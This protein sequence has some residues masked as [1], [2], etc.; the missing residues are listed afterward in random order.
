[1]LA[2]YV[3]KLPRHGG[4]ELGDT[5][6]PY[7]NPFCVGAWMADHMVAF[8]PR[9][10]GRNPAQHLGLL[11]PHHIRAAI[12]TDAAQAGHDG[13]RRRLALDAEQAGGKITQVRRRVAVGD[14]HPAESGA[15]HSARQGGQ[16]LGVQRR[17]DL[18]PETARGLPR[19]EFGHPE[20][21]VAPF[22]RGPIVRHHPGAEI[23]R[24]PVQ[25]E[26]AG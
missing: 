17:P 6:V 1:M 14:L 15:D 13:D 10:V 21:E 18:L 26:E 24:S 16:R 25:G 4:D 19:R 3:E 12:R 2:Q 7:Q 11:P 9:R 22:A 5:A 23:G 20:G 8:R